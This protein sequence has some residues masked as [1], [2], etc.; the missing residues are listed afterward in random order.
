MVRAVPLGDEKVYGWIGMNTDITERKEA[1]KAIQESKAHL[2]QLIESLPQ[3][4]WTTHPD[5]VCDYLSKQ[6]LEYTGIAEAKQ[7]GYGWVEQIHPD[8]RAAAV[9]TWHQAVAEQTDFRIE[10]RIRRHDGQ[11]RW[12]DTLATPLYDRQGRL[13]KWFGSNT[14]IEDKK[15]VEIENQQ[16]NEELDKFVYSASHDLR[17]PLVGM[18]GLVTIAGK[19][20]QNPM[21]KDYLEMMGGSVR[22]LDTVL[23]SIL[24]YSY[25]VRFPIQ[26]EL[27]NMTALVEE[28]L[29]TLEHLP[30]FHQVEKTIDIHQEAE[31][32]SDRY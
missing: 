21:V 11:Y 17:S 4:V 5:G 14:D 16:I 30:G 20:A 8:D 9:T 31:L 22:K 12:F 26:E 27:I 32:I 2:I 3:L 13:L 10:Y 23:Q 15:Q 19:E 18:M 1:E 28:C 6:W 29:D 24:E 7:L 25:N